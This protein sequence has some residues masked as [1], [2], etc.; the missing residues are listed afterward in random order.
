MLQASVLVFIINDI[1]IK[2]MFAYNTSHF[3]ALPKILMRLTNYFLLKR[4]S[5]IN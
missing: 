4:S 5:Q 3:F 2:P 1:N